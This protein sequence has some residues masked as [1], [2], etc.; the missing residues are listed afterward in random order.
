MGESRHLEGRW[1]VAVTTSPSIRNDT[2]LSLTAHPDGL[3][4]GADDADGRIV[5]WG[6]AAASVDPLSGLVTLELGAGTSVAV[7]PVEGA[8]PQALV[9]AVRD[10]RAA[11]AATGRRHST[12]GEHPAGPDRVLVIYPSGDTGEEIDADTFLAAVAADA[13]LR[14]AN[15]WTLVSLVALPV[16]HAG[17][18]MFGVEGSGYTTKAAM[19]GLYARS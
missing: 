4:L 6:L 15:G 9:A 1:R 8:D 18:K 5:P 7:W 11:E 14:A 10:G 17:V 3:E 16:R 2:L 19:G 13:E 12:F